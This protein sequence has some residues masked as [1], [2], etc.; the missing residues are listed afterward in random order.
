M[1]AFLER[2]TTFY[3]GTWEDFTRFRPLSHFGSLAAAQEIIASPEKK[4]EIL[5]IKAEESAMAYYNVVFYDLPGK[6]I[7]AQLNICQTYEIRDWLG[8]PI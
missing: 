5:D 4:H 7:P 2:N 3:H 6:I 1:T 8:H